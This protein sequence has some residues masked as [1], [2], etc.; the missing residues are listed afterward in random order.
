MTQSCCDIAAEL[1]RKFPKSKIILSTGDNQG[2]GVSNSKV[3][4]NY[5]ESKGIPKPNLIEE[6]ESMNTYENLKNSREIINNSSEL[7]NKDI[8]LIAY[9]LHM[10][11][12]VSISNKLGM[13]D[14]SWISG[15]SDA[16]RAYGI[17][18]VFQTRN[19]D[20]IFV[21]EVMATI[22]STIRGWI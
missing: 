4:M 8:T 16:G 6:A 14:F 3:M 19:K 12:V 11:R 10:K 1:W 2:L 21:Y 5:L 17:K 13:K 20:M 9:E 7:S 15:K 18:G 22:Y